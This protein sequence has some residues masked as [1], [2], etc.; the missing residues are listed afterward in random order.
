MAKRVRY[1]GGILVHRLMPHAMALMA[2]PLAGENAGDS[3]VL[4][5]LQLPDSAN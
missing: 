4:S 2:G 3:L 1:H 5:A